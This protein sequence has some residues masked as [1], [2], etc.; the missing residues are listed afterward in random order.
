MTTNNIKSL[1]FANLSSI[2]QETNQMVSEV[3]NLVGK[4]SYDELEAILVPALEKKQAALDGSEVP[5]APSAP[6]QR[7]TD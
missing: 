7:E 4:F 2:A 3:A 1:L 6:E 5:A